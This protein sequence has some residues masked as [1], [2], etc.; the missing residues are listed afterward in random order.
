MKQL[1]IS[2]IHNGMELE[3]TLYD[4]NNKILLRSGATL[5]TSIIEKLKNMGFT[6]LCIK[7][8]NNN[9]IEIETCLSREQKKEII[10]SL[11]SLDFYNYKNIDYKD[12]IK[13][14]E[15]IIEGVSKSKNIA[16]DLLD[17]RNDKNYNYTNSLAIAELTA[18]KAK[19]Y[20]KD[21]QLVFKDESLL[22]I[23]QTAL[24]HSIGKSC[25]NNKVREKLGI[26]E[27]KKRKYTNICLSTIT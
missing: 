27:Y 7:D 8:E 3:Q 14:A 20:R 19:E 5:T 10:N 21:D 23:T 1:H 13:S 16:I 24:L 15:T 18:A 2:N 17:I 4:E 26:K 22:A 12:V 9:D 25:K 11:K 6:M